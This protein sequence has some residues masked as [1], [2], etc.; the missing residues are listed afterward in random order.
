MFPVNA[1]GGASYLR[2][3]RDVYP[4]IRLVPTGG[5]RIDEVATYLDA[6]AFALGVGGALVDK[7]AIERGDAGPIKAAAA[8]LVASGVH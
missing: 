2:A 3:V 1:M 7:G 6:G 5:I 4:H 8:A